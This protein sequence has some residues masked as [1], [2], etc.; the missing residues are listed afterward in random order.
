MTSPRSTEASRGAHARERM[1]LAALD[2]F[3]RHGFDATTTRM[4][5][6]AASMNLGAIPYYFGTKEDLYAQAAGHLAS[7]IEQAQAA[8]L[9]RLREQS[10]RT[11]DTQGLIDLMLDFLLDE[12]R[13]LLADKVPA[14]WVQFFLRAQAEHGEA[15]ERVF[16][17]V[18]EPVQCCLNQV[19]ARI[20]QRAPDDF[21]V[22]TLSFFL[23]HQF[24]CLRLADSVLMRRLEWDAITPQRVEQLLDA[25][26]P[27][28]RAQLLSAA[29]LPHTP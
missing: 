28:L 5:A 8:P 12:T 9:A 3:G 6:Q 22:R 20:M 13:L 26:T 15:F 23:L 16:A 14:S 19:L 17:Q 27:T 24:I 29:N 7:F 4:I 1:V 25:L 21:Q 18:V 2:L 10:A 11:P